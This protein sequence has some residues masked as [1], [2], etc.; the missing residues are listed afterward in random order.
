MKFTLGHGLRKDLI[1]IVLVKA[2][3]DLHLKR[4]CS[5]AA[6]WPHLTS[7][8]AV[9]STP[10]DRSCTSEPGLLPGEASQ[11]HP[12]EPGLGRDLLCLL[13]MHVAI[14]WSARKQA[15]GNFTHAWAIQL[16]YASV[17]VL[18]LS[19]TIPGGNTDCQLPKHTS[20]TWDG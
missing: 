3:K 16:H 6:L 18:H 8:Q 5:Q 14:N 12:V 4:K 1:R 13:C 17:L 9:N 20:V 2:I 7:L 11:G 10:P 15:M 19:V